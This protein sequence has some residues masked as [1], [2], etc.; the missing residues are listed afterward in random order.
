MELKCSRENLIKGI[1]IIETA[2]SSKATLPILTNF[3]IEIE[4]NKSSK[5]KLVSTDLEI[6]VKCYIDGAIISEGGVTIPAKKFGGIIKELPE[7]EIHIK[8]DEKNQV[9]IRAGKS[10]FTLSGISKDEFPTIPD[11]VEEK[12]ISVETKTIKEMIK[13]VLFAV[14]TDETR[15]VL[16][17]IYCVIEHNNI[18]LVSTDGRR[19]AYITRPCEGIKS[20][21]KAIIPGKT[22]NELSRILS[23]EEDSEVKIS[24]TEN[25]AA[26]KVNEIVLI[27]RLIDGAFPNYEQVIP[28]KYQQKIKVNVKSLLSATKQVSLLTQDKG[29]AVKFSFGKN[30]LRVSAQAQGIGSGEVDVDVSY[31]GPPIEIAFNPTYIMDILKNVSEEEC[32]FE[33]NGPIDACV[34]KTIGDDNYLCVV[35]PM[36]I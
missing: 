19:L 28:K 32:E 17:G 5:I 30:L 1:Q 8:S 6:A 20:G 13:K 31:S 18:K 9:D 12:A 7:E 22:I 25:Q 16:T 26:F 15:Y 4:K 10:H 3:L 23:I 34:V 14:S 24:L 21:A 29:G 27:S 11:F 36:R 35:M 33:I 2:V